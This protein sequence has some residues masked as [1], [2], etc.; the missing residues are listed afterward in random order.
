M[1]IILT[2]S[3][4]HGTH[5]FNRT[6]SRNGTNRPPSEWIAIQVPALTDGQAFN[7]GQAL[8]QSRQ[9]RRVAPRMVNTPTLLVGIAKCGHSGAALIQNTGK[10]G[11]Y[12]YYACSSRL[13]KGTSACHGQRI[14]MDKLDRI[15]MREVAHRIL[16]PE[17]LKA[18]LEDYLKT[19]QQRDERHRDQLRNLRHAH[20]EAE[21]GLARLLDLV[22]KG[23]IDTGDAALRERMV[24]LRFR[25]D[26]LAAEI[27]TLAQRLANADPMITP[28]KVERLSVTLRDALYNGAAELRQSYARL[29]L[30]EVTLKGD[31]ITITGSKAV[32]ARASTEAVGDDSP[33][34]LSFVRKWCTRQDSNL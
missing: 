26:E 18:L 12:R 10:V 34:V 29:I 1:H 23:L 4:Y 8:L 27:A 21:A 16:D 25:R 20:A 22:E 28:E 9:P 11:Q 17:R 19:A 33:T 14:P 3:T 13:K 30:S 32:L 5:Y 31:E 24:T 15:V 6:D 2:C 7:T